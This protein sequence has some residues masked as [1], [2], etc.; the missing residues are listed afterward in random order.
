MIQIKDFS[1]H[2]VIHVDINKFTDKYY[3]LVNCETGKFAH[4]YKTKDKYTTSSIVYSDGVTI[5]SES[6]YNAL[7]ENV[8]PTL[9]IVIID[10]QAREIEYLKKTLE[11]TIKEK[12]MFRKSYDEYFTKFNQIEAV[13]YKLKSILNI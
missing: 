1:K 11:F 13:V 4:P 9:G 8:K 10:Q 5:V 2:V 6:V 3:T 12:E 7:L